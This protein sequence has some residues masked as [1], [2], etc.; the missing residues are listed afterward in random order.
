MRLSNTQREEIRKQLLDRKFSKRKKDFIKRE[1]RFRNFLYNQWYDAKVRRRINGLPDG[2]LRTRSSVS[3]RIGVN[4]YGF[5]YSEPRRFL[6]K[7]IGGYF[8]EATMKFSITSPVGSAWEEL[9]ADRSKQEKEYNALHSEITSALW[10]VNT[11][12]QLLTAWPEI[13]DLVEE[14]V[15][16]PTRKLLPVPKLD[17]LNHKLGLQTSSV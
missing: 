2:W 7:D 4:S 13:A 14:V 8:K 1:E 5:A 15:K 11:K 17:V 6:S 10:S 9:E 12:K 16:A 3:V